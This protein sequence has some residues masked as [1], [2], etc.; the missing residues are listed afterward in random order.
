MTLREILTLVA[1]FL[2]VSVS[3][4]S[5]LLVSRNARRSTSVQLENVDLTRIRDLRSETKDLTEMLSKARGEADLFREKMIEMN[6]W[7][8]GLLRE[9]MEM[10]RYAQ[11]PGVDI[12]VWLDRYGDDSPHSIG[13]ASPR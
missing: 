1:A 2:V 8:N 5:M 7:G 11:M 9:R 4:V 12:N 3:V 13:S 10:V 6:E